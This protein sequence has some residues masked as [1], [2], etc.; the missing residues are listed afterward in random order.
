GLGLVGIRGERAWISVS[1]SRDQRQSDVTRALLP[2]LLST[3]D[4]RCSGALLV[5]VGQA[6]AATQGLLARAGFRQLDDLVTL[7]RE[8]GVPAGTAA[9]NANWFSHS[10]ALTLLGTRKTAVPWSVDTAAFRGAAQVEGVAV[11]LP[12]GGLGWAIF[13][14]EPAGLNHLVLHTQ[15]G[16][17]AAVGAALLSHL[18]QRYPHLDLAAAAVRSSDAHLPAFAQ[19]GYHEVGR[20]VQLQLNAPAAERFPFA[21]PDYQRS[22]LVASG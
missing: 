20:R 15:S 5:E 2:S 8:A 6:D 10:T 9:G 18:H 4:Q 11:S 22:E 19:H 12:E 17:P 13:Q 21:R 3:V 1:V 14:R 16:D 7:R